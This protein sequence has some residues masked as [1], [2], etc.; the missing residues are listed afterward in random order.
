MNR[1]F[2]LLPAGVAGE[3]CIA[4]EGVARGYLNRVE[5]SA[6]RFVP[7]PNKPGQRM[8]C[9]GDRVRLSENGDLEYLGRIDQQVKIRGFRIELGEI[10]NR[11]LKYDAVKDAVVIARSDNGKE[12]ALSAYLVTGAD[13]AAADL[14]EYLGRELPYYM[15]PSF[16]VTLDKIPLTANGK[17]DFK[18]LPAPG[19]T[20]GDAYVPPRD[21]VE[22]KLVEIWAEILEL[23]PA[24]IG[25]TTDFFELGGHSLKA[26]RM[27]SRIRSAFQVDIPLGMLFEYPTIEQLAARIMENENFSDVVAKLV[28]M[29]EEEAEKLLGQMNNASHTYP[30]K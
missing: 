7:D 29:S 4:G 12:T 30:L 25:V 2:K 1:Q 26:T 11:L 17:T 10:T 23:E 27:V 13:V 5:L 22:K 14:R 21:D 18:A 16:F 28:D 6:E 24:V 8:Y 3:L 9:S 19:V 15:I 20:V